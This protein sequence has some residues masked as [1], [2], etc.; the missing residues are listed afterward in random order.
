[1]FKPE[2][3]KEQ[4]GDGAEFTDLWIFPMCDTVKKGDQATSDLLT[5]AYVCSKH[6]CENC[7]RYMSKIGQ[8]EKG[9]QAVCEQCSNYVT[10]ED[11]T[12]YLSLVGQGKIKLIDLQAFNKVHYHMKSKYR[13][14][15]G[16]KVNGP[17]DQNSEK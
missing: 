14:P 16:T 2:K 7:I 15:M 1:M 12:S 4:M 5:T 6:P 10:F 9:W 17:K 3:P 8:R 13:A 11:I